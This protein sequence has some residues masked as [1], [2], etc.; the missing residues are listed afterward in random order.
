MKALF[1]VLSLVALA[2]PAAAK[3][4]HAG[5]LSIKDAVV[6]AVPPGVPN[7]A[8]YMTIVNMGSRPDKLLAASCACATSVE[9]H[10]SRVM[11]GEA[12]MMPAGPVTIPAKGQVS[13]SPGGYH[14]MVM[15]LKAPLKDG[16]RAEMTLRFLH[17]GTVKVDFMASTRIEAKPAPDMAGMKGMKMP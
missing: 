7:T 12:M 2:A 5:G 8:G 4:A 17:A 16:A 3:P 13:F 11:N 10:V 1:A 6:R 14:L 9:A 15:G